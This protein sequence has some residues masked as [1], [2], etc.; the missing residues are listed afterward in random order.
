MLGYMIDLYISFE[1]V[2]RS[3]NLF[4]AVKQVNK[5]Y[6]QAFEG[7][8]SNLELGE[9]TLLWPL[10]KC[11]NFN[12]ILSAV[13]NS[14]PII[15]TLDQVKSAKKITYIYPKMLK[16]KFYQDFVETRGFCFI[17]EEGMN[18]KTN[19]IQHAIL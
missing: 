6:T 7:F 4:I 16:H 10:T 13:F 12:L 18:Y 3:H 8:T 9:P 11:E 14:K 2:E 1:T 19:T 17:H 15:T 5:M